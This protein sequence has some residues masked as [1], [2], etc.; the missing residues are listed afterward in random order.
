MASQSVFKVGRRLH[1][2][3]SPLT[4]LF[5]LSIFIYFVGDKLTGSVLPS[6]HVDPGEGTPQACWQAPLPVLQSQWPLLWFLETGSHTVAQAD[7]SWC[8]LATA[9]SS[10]QYRTIMQWW[11]GI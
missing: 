2:F 9:H 10:S 3:V 8:E 5:Y 6:Q 1:F 11:K 4:Y 7:D